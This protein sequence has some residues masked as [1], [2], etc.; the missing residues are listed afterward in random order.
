MHETEL[1][2]LDYFQRL[3]AQLQDAPHGRRGNMI[4]QAAEFLK[5]S[6]AQVYNRLRAVGW[7]SGRRLRID[8]GDSRFSNDDAKTLSAIMVESSRANGKRLLG[9]EDAMDI[10]LANNLI[11][12]T[13]IT[14]ASALRIMRAR[15]C[16]PDQ[17]ARPTP[18]M[19]MRSLHPNHVW[20][21]DVSVC[22]LFYLDDGG[23][24]AM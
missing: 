3:A 20:Q 10:A 11:E 1:G 13:G 12:D 22:V 7:R 18:H 9:V 16:H 6:R 2:T 19:P 17:I 23:M 5:L 15:G 4:D 21:F 8:K 24:G 14:P